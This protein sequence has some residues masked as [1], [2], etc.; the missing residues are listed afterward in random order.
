MEIPGGKESM[1]PMEQEDGLLLS[2]IIPVYNVA[3]Y[4]EKSLDSLVRQTLE[5]DS[6]EVIVIDDAST[7][8]SLAIARGFEARFP[9]FRVI[10]LPAHS[11]GAIGYPSNTGIRIARGK[12]IGF[13]DSDDWVDPRMFEMLLEAAE[14]HQAE[15]AVCDFVEFD[16][17]TSAVTSS[18][19]RAFLDA[20]GRSERESLTDRRRA[21]LKLSPVPW[22]KIYLRSFLLGQRIFFPEGNWFFEDNPFHWYTV[23]LARKAVVVP[24][25]LVTHRMNRPGQTMGA[26]PVE[27]LAVIDH[28]RSI[29]RFLRDHDRHDDF[30]HEFLFWL[31]GQSF[32][33]L[34][35]LGFFLARRYVREAGSLLGRVSRAELVEYFRRYPL[36]P[37][38]MA[39]IAMV[40]EGRSFL[41]PLYGFPPFRPMFAVWILFRLYGWK[42]GFRRIRRE[43]WKAFFD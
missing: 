22:R 19:D 4:L 39:G 16:E 37:S 27:L 18:Y 25:A 41:Y 32:W 11:P 34:P 24:E 31:T 13:L 21:L 2:I 40:F 43:P 7:D 42:R 26:D 36:S 3:P 5:E 10:A 20:A 15:L 38:S 29:L 35:R 1:A 8:S 28:G 12:Y 9:N 23:L 6:F 33:I 14:T 17:V 30:Q